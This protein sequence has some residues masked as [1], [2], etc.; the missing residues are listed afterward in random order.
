MED[1]CNAVAWFCAIKAY[2]PDPLLLIATLL[3]A[4]FT[5]WLFLSTRNMAEKT[6]ELA[7]GASEANRLADRHHQEG[8]MPLVTLK[9]TLLRDFGED[10][11]T[12][13]KTVCTFT[14]E[15]GV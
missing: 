14:L 11:L 4:F 15:G 9:A 10:P 1:A 5:A 8:L 12:P 13:Q 7:T 6:A 2:E 3:L